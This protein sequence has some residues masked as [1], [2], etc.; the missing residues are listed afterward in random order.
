[1][2]EGPRPLDLNAYMRERD[3]GADNLAV[4]SA[5]LVEGF[6]YHGPLSSWR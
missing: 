6:C 2:A 5:D 3:L 1:M 4:I